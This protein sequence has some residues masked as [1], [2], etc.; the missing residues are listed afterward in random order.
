MKVQDNGVPTYYHWGWKWLPNMPTRALQYRIQ[1]GLASRRL[2]AR[3]VKEEGWPDVIHAHCALSAGIM[4]LSI[5]TH[6]NIPY[7]LTEHKT[8]YARGRVR[9]WKISLAKKAFENANAR[10]VVSPQLGELLEALLG[11]SIVP[12]KW[13]PNIVDASFVA[14]GDHSK[15]KEKK[16]FSFLNI[17]TMIEKKGQRELL[18][19][20]ASFFK[21]KSN[22]YLRLGG[23]GRLR[24]E[25]MHL[26]EELGISDQ[27]VFLGMLDRDQVRKE[28][29]SCDAFV[30]SSHYETFG[31]VLIEALACGKPVVATAC[32]GPE[33]IV[34]DRNG[35]LVPVRDA[36]ALGKAMLSVQIKINE[37]NGHL[38]RKECLERFGPENV[39]SNLLKIYDQVREG[40][41]KA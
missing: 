3:Y 25:L 19:T 29:L 27:V 21:G 10:I 35:V 24:R 7:V 37:Y 12:W 26:A 2:F 36:T 6:Y 39:T 18:Q 9:G 17:G 22:T 40:F 31:V 8:S 41:P 30:L 16:N 13:V 23:D 4:A 32:G 28:M 20:F 38:I 1:W 14:C 33:C 34:N 11:D 5:K 15:E